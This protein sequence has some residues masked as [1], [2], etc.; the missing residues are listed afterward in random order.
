MTSD[1]PYKHQPPKAFWHSAIAERSPLDVADMWDP[2]F[3]LKKRHKIATYGS[4][5]AQHIGKALH[6]RGYKWLRCEPAVEGMSPVNLPRYGYELFS[7]RTGNIYTTAQLR[8]WTE[9]A[10]DP[11]LYP[12]EIWQENGRY[13]DPFRPNLEPDGFGSE[14][15][16]R[17]MQA[18]TCA[19][20]KASIE[21][22]DFLVF[23]LGLT[24]RWQ[25]KT[26]GY[27]YAMCPGTVA[28]K[29][30]SSEHAFSN[31]SVQEVEENLQKAL[32]NLREMNP[33]LRVIL[34]VSPVHLAA[35]ATQ[36]HVLVASAHAKAIL[37][38]VAGQMAVSH[39]FIDYFPSYEIINNP[40]YRG[41]LRQPALRG[42]SPFGVHTVMETFFGALQAKFGKPNAPR[43]AGIEG[44]DPAI[45]DDLVCEE[46]LLFAFGDTT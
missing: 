24:E 31:M 23:T 8:Q 20:F 21:Q 25:H 33:E 38:A 6:S 2:K 5:F 27:E 39:D 32:V 18:T 35:T 3:D 40:L 43:P 44:V 4:C 15:E 13:F 10:A 7:S 19:A 14:A 16:L 30:D 17:R 22:A 11:A 37:R 36:E 46:E 9:W 29:F 41:T 28:G 26:A 34:T 12:A 45:I 1:N 42:V